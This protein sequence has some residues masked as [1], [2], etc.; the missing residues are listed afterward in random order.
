MMN[1]L[2]LDQ[3]IT[4]CPPIDCSMP[5]IDV[6]NKYRIISTKTV[7][8]KAIN[9][10]WVIFDTYKS[11]NKITSQHFVLMTHD[12]ILKNDVVSK[13]GIPFICLTNSHDGKTSFKYV[14]GY[15]SF[16]NN[17]KIFTEDAYMENCLV[18]HKK[19]NEDDA[20]TKLNQTKIYF[21]NFFD[22]LKTFENRFLNEKETKTFELYFNNKL[23]K[24][25]KLEY[26]DQNNL[27]KIS[28]IVHKQLGRSFKS[29]MEFSQK[30]WK[31][32]CA[33]LIFYEDNLNSFLLNNE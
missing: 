12:V 8:E 29:N 25:I 18:N 7:L 24:N 28:N 11:G 4:K 33:S 23:K 31:A 3:A 32:M 1:T 27:W 22:V 2:T 30:V 19:H 15:Y 14:L 17:I 5:S 10:G 9:D 20:I 21:R 13:H 16:S 6:S 26:N